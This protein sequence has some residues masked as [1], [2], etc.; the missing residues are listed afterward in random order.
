MENNLNQELESAKTEQS[1]TA[2]KEGAKGL[3]ISLKTFIIELLD[4]RHDTDREVTI[5]AIKSDISFKGATAWILICSIFV[6]SVGL[7]A[8]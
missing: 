1:K 6:A 4:F 5:V 7:N 8:N 3:W 2:V